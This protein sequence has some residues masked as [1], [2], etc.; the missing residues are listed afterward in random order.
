MLTVPNSKADILRL[1]YTI[2]IYTPLLLHQKGTFTI[3][4]NIIGTSDEFAASSRPRWG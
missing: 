3:L 1:D 2:H 4:V